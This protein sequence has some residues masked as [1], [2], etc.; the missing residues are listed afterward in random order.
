MKDIQINTS[1]TQDVIVDETMLASQV[2]SGS[3]NVYA[4]PWMIAFME[5]T[6][7]TC[8]EQFLDKEETS[9]GVMINTTHDAA[10]PQ[11]MKVTI[12][13][14]ISAVDRK[15]VTFSIVAKDE[16]EGIGIATHERFV[17]HKAKFEARTQEKRIK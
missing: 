4:T 10:T 11:G 7:A 12:T 1:L 8:L 2:G 13:A 6:A 17:V 15:K 16:V 14:T 3:V 5:H 9:V